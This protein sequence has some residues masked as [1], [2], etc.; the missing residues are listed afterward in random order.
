MSIWYRLHASRYANE[1]RLRVARQ[2][3]LSLASGRESIK[4]MAKLEGSLKE[5][6]V[7]RIDS[8]KPKGLF[9]TRNWSTL[10]SASVAV[11]AVLKEM[12]LDKEATDPK[13]A[14]KRMKIAA[15]IAPLM[16]A[17]VNYQRQYIVPSELGPKPVEKSQ[18]D[19]SE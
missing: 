4:H 5:F 6:T 17:A 16:T 18:T 19:A 14:E 10:D 3:R 12:G 11:R 7:A 8:Q 1:F 13:Q 2:S 9:E 15:V